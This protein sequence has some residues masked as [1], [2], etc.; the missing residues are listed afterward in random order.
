VRDDCEAG[1]GGACTGLCLGDC[2]AACEGRCFA[3]AADQAGTCLPACVGACDGFAAAC[4]GRCLGACDGPCSSHGADGQCAGSC[5]GICTGTCDHDAPFPC[6]GTCGGL[7]RV[8][9]TDQEPCA[10]CRG[11]CSEGTCAGQCRGHYRVRGCDQPPN[12]AGVVACQETGRFLAFAA[13]TCT[14]SAA[15]VRVTYG[16]TFEGDRAAHAGLALTLERVLARLAR[17]R[18]L[19]GL[20]V[21]GADV[22]GELAPGALDE[23]LLADPATHPE[24]AALPYLRDDL[25]LCGMC[26]VASR[27]HLPLSAFLARLGALTES[28]AGGDFAVTAGAMPCVGPAFEEAH[29]LLRDLLPVTDPELCA[30]CAAGEDVDPADLAPDRDAGLYRVVDAIEALFQGLGL[31]G[32]DD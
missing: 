16:G 10:L 20:L 18:A 11:D 12:C 28:A 17:Q 26:V 14:P 13:L 31:A 3:P 15:E 29:G 24:L 1:L 22:T 2:G 23:D 9:N 25:A 30:R 19:L 6:A 4:P 32:A 27:R 8:P 5:D 7:C 21:D